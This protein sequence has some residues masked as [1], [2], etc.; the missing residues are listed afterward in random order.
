ML[1]SPQ[2]LIRAF[3]QELSGAVSLITP[4]LHEQL[5]CILLMLLSISK[6]HSI[7]GPVRVSRHTQHEAPLSMPVVHKE[8]ATL[9]LIAD[10][11]Y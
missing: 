8:L 4:L 11:I 7:A 6:V 5:A 3:R 1:G 10:A 2:G 9:I